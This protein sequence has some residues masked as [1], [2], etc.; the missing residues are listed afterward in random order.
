MPALMIAAPF[1]PVE[2]VLNQ[3]GENSVDLFDT[4]EELDEMECPECGEPLDEEGNCPNECID[5]EEDDV[6]DFDDDYF[7]DDLEDVDFFIDEDME[8]DYF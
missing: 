6:D 3:I 7:D 8:E 1:R 4:F 2:L 5:P